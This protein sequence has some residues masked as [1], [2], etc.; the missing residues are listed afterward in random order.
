VVVTTNPVGVDPF[1]GSSVA[2]I[3]FQV[4]LVTLTALLIGFATQ[5]VLL[6]FVGGGVVGSVGIGG[7]E[8]TEA[9]AAAVKNDALAAGEVPDL[10]RPLFDRVGVPDP[11]LRLMQ[12][13]I[14]LE[15]E[16][17]K[18]AQTHELPAGLTVPY[19]VRGLVD[20][21]KMS[22]KLGSAVTALASMGDR[23]SHGAEL[24]QDAVSL[25]TDAY[26][27]ALAKIGGKIKR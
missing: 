23:I 4:L 27:Q 15:L 16:V 19:V 13:R 14:S 3:S 22:P 25:L 26:A 12:S 17:R 8:V 2:G 5:R 24:S 9:E 10:S 20:K 6:G 7:G 21:K 18:L 1:L 11:R